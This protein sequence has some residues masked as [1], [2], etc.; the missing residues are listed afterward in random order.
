MYTPETN[1]IN[2]FVDTEIEFT[3]IIWSANVCNKAI[4]LLIQSSQLIDIV[5]RKRI[6]SYGY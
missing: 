3:F 2:N 5:L 4:L 6:I 1:K